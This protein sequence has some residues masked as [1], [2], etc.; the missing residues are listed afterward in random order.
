MAWPLVAMSV[1]GLYAMTG[2]AS[3]T[4]IVNEAD[5]VP[6]EFVAVMV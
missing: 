2:T 1:S 3:L 5:P 4:V 6:P